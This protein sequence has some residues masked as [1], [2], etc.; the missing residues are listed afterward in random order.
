MS[1]DV[2]PAVSKATVLG[3]AVAAAAGVVLVGL[4]CLVVYS[5]RTV[6]VQTVIA[7]FLALSLDPPVRWMVRRGIRRGLA[8]T[9][10]FLVALAALVP[11][12]WA[13]VPP[14]VREGT[15]LVTDLPRYLADLRG[16]SAGVAAADDR[17]HLGERLDDAMAGLPG[18]A[19]RSAWAYGQQFMGVLSSTVLVAVLT[20]YLML[21]L[22]RLRRAVVGLVP[23]RH[24]DAVQESLTV[25]SDKVGSYMIGNLAIS[26][27]AGAAA[28]LAMAALRVP[29]ALPLAVFVA[30][31]D[32]I[33]M[34]GAT[35]GATACVFVALAA[36]RLWPGAVLLTVFFVVYQQLENYVIAPRV[37]RNAVSMPALS[38]LIAGLVGGALLGLVGVLMAIPVAAAAKAVVVTLRRQAAPPQPDAAEAPPL[39]PE[40]P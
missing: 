15:G 23:A 19:G 7:L 32:L 37:L 25:V 2:R 22:P 39:E 29:F 20:I 38:V 11:L 16:R 31:A 27:I 30:L 21:D 3:W 40:G 36:T 10:I 4:A 14:L 28:F 5:V 1:R 17:F 35:L 34:V 9:V 13:L 26:A 18:W 12:V 6:L 8:V 33:P 24:R